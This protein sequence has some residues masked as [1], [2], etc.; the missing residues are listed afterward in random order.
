M[1]RLDPDTTSPGSSC[2]DSHHAATGH[3]SSATSSGR[4]PRISTSKR[5]NTG[6][7]LTL[8]QR[9]IE[10]KAR[11]RSEDG[12]PHGAEVAVGALLGSNDCGAVIYSGTWHR[13]P[14]AAKVGE[15]PAGRKGARREPL[16]L[17]T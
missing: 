11:R 8:L 12:R 5:L 3:H 15:R 10:G 14:V 7:M 2:S 16:L 13:V 17:A 9:D 1:I 6:A 4:L